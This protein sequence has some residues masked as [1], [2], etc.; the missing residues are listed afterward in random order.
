MDEACLRV[1]L[2]NP[3]Y[4]NVFTYGPQASILFP[5]LGL[6]Y[7]AAY[8]ND[9]AEVRLLD[10]RLKTGSLKIIEK[11][12]EQFQPDYTGIS[13]NFTCQINIARR[14]AN[15]AKKWGSRTILGGWH[16]TLVPDETLGYESVDIIIRGE[17]EITFRELIQN[18]S[19]IGIPGLSYKLNGKQV[20]NPNRELM[21]LKH[22]RQPNRCL[23]T[24]T[25]K[26]TYNFFGF[27][28]DCIETSRGCPFSCNFC[29]IHHFYRK[30][31]RKRKFNHVV[32]ELHSDEVRKRAS[33][34]FIVDDNFV[35]DQKFVSELCNAI[36]QT[37]INKYF[38]AQARVDMIAHHPEIFKKMADAGFIYLFL[39]LESFS[40]RTLK[41]LNKRIKFREIKSALKILHDYGFIIQGN[42]ILG[43]DLEDTKKDLE[44]MIDITKVLDVD[45]PT[46]SMLTPL[47]GTKLMEH[48]IEKNLFLTKDWHDF[49]WSVPI[50][51]YPNLS[52]DDLSYYLAKAYKE[53][54]SFKRVQAGMKNF[55]HMRGLK[56]H[57]S[58]MK[59]N[60]LIRVATHMMKNLCK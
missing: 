48:V 50:I 1:L 43:A 47:P 16:P 40:D 23:R 31:Y 22:I 60:E 2:I 28:V 24:I 33:H 26:K 38:M 20:H 51:K 55:I 37:G 30:S 9:I 21:D 54:M 46:F 12:L 34:I 17:G 49:N 32:N 15:I 13:C 4:P 27:S 19:P 39:G 25:A 8:I 7:I 53:T 42:I 44:S 3:N 41:K 35:V 36:I 52:A 6:E 58:R 11:T 5:P 45:F 18:N 57:M 59:P 10:N 29:C 56:F 14:I